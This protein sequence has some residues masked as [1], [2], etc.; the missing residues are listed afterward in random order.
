MKIAILGAGRFG[1]ALG[2]LL[3]ERG[4]DL[5]YYDPKKEKESLKNVVTGAGMILVTMP[6]ETVPH[7]LVYLPKD[8]PLIIASKGFLTER[9]FDEFSK[10]MVLSGSGFAEEIKER[11]SAGWTVTDREI[12]GLFGAE[13]ID[14]D[15]TDDARG[16]LLCGAL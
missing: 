7:I 2:E 1:T 16:V 8:L 4:Y 9:I 14:F 10:V 5:D 15:F 6:S 11:K 13:W 12:E 3:A